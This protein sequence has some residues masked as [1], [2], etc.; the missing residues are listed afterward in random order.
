MS[1]GAT[2]TQEAPQR[3][4]TRAIFRDGIASKHR[5]A[6]DSASSSRSLKLTG[7]TSSE[8]LTHCA[9]QM[10]ACSDVQKKKMSTGGRWSR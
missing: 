1:P 9:V 5:C 4:S 3:R 2:V 6:S 8:S 10:Q 7:A